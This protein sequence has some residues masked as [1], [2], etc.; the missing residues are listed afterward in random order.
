MRW[1]F[2]KISSYDTCPYGWY[3]T[4]VLKEKGE[5]NAFAQ[6]G[7]FCHEILERYA[8]GELMEW[9]LLDEYVNNFKSFVTYNFPPNKYVS[10]EES[11]YKDGYEYFKNFNGFGKFKI[12]GSEIEIDMKLN[13]KYNLI[14]Y[15]DLL[16]E[17]E[18]KDLVVW[19]HKS[20]SKFANKKEQVEY[21]K[22]LYIYSYYVKEKYGKFPK[23]LI[24]NMFRKNQRV[25]IPFSEK[26]YN[27]AI[28]WAV[29]TIEYIGTLDEFNAKQDKFFCNNLCNHR[30]TCENKI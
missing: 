28:D 12:I 21:A 14:G 29:N 19:D 24:F 13:D 4:Y 27:D 3:K 5:D 7:G 15:I 8:D 22:Q 17:D 30:N 1:S 9:D 25:V 10:L 26:D 2:S 11:Y 20:K 6:F 16:L 23:F 18:N